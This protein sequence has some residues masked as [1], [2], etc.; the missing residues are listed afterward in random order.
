MHTLDLENLTTGANGASQAGQL[1]TR[2]EISDAFK[3][4]LSD[5]Y[6]DNA[7]YKEDV[8]QAN[9]FMEEISALRGEL[10]HTD[11]LVKCLQTRDKLDIKLSKLFAYARL[12]LDSD[13]RNTAYQKM[14]EDAESLLTKA[15]SATAFIDPEL[16][17][18]PNGHLKKV[19]GR[20]K[21]LR[22]YQFYIEDLLRQKRH[23]LSKTEEELLAAASEITRAPSHIFTT[24]TNADLKFPETLAESGE[25]I[26][27][28]EG[29]YN[30]LIRSTN[31]EVR[32]DAF[33]H[34]FGT[35]A[36]YR[37]A[38]AAMLSSHIKSAR[39]QA[40]ARKYPST[41]DA[42]LERTNVSRKVY[43]NMIDT[44]HEDLAP[45]HRYIEVK[46]KALRLDEMH[47]YDLY[48][49]ITKELKREFPYQDGL[50]LVFD[51]LRPLGETYI[52]DL[53]RGAKSGWI[54]IYENQGKRT[55][56]YSWGV[57]GVHP[58]VLLNY[59]N[60]YGAV[61]TL[62]HELGHAMHSYY[63]NQAQEY[64]NSSYTIFCAEVASTTN[65][66][67]LLD[68]MLEIE[69]DPQKRMY[70]INQYLEQVRTTVYRQAMFAEFE[71]ITHRKAEQGEALTADVFEEIWMDLN[72]TYYGKEMVVDEALNIEWARIP[73]FY[74]SFYVYQYVT[75]Y[76]A[77][78]TLANHLQSESRSAR[79]RYLS[80]LKSGGSDYS[81][82]L[83][84]EAG[85]DMSAPEPLRITLS[86]FQTRLDELEKF[87]VNA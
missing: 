9:D 46:K 15:S 58:Y 73:H 22:A 69:R 24:M 49:P 20:T 11:A 8:K 79:E 44:V 77:A 47:M 38:F 30:A 33:N 45:L 70:Y 76:A 19:V 17:S 32:K 26:Q 82:A 84:K 66:I 12:H 7:A 53:A 87:L 41:L 29:R 18:L 71:M 2:D 80:Y 35:Y 14:T 59:D 25:K 43:T 74:R 27:L 75:G 67:L 37:N 5:I 78:T 28:S 55:G 61:S 13:A 86:K 10:K 65:E 31:R 48:A 57:Y 3:W 62:A 72:Q 81:I 40:K 85:V 39:F 83:L 54:D 36:D 42:A 21:A 52:N 23:I 16:L 56:A 6:R 63:S 68:H 4:N 60:R 50:N 64:I 34:L 1:P 51:S